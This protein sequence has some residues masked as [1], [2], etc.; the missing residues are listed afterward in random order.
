MKGDEISEMFVNEI[1][2]VKR[3]ERRRL[4][5][6]VPGCAPL[7]VWAVNGV[8]PGK[9]LVVTAG[10]H[11]C[12]YIGPTAARRLAEELDPSKMSGRAIILPMLNP[13]GFFQGAKQVM[14]EDGKNLNREFPGD[15]DGTYTQRTAAAIERALYPLADFIADLHGGD[16]YEELTP[17]VFFPAAAGEKVERESLA[18]ACALTA[19][20]LVAS[21]AKNGLYS[22]AAQLGVPSLLLERGCRGLWSAEEEKA[23]LDDLRRLLIHLGILEGEIKRAEQ[24]EIRDAVYEEAPSRGCWRPAVHAGERVLAGQPI[25]ELRAFDGGLIKRVEAHGDCVI[26][27]VTTALGVSEGDSLAACALV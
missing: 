21:S 25:G 16:V 6:P 20:L 24:R 8:G 1:E 14:P 27:Y 4:A 19:P 9:T 11:G 5:V 12:E 3:G 18:A 26:M 22:R 7:D 2:C 15:T 10:V 23:V 17:L 13:T